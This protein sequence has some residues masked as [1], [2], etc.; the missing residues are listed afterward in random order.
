MTHLQRG[1]AAVV[2]LLL[3][4]AACSGDD[5]PDLSLPRDA[6]VPDASTTDE[7]TDPLLGETFHVAQATH[8]TLVV[9][10]SAQEGAD[11]LLTLVAAEQVSGKIVC[12]VV[13]QVGDWVE[14]RLPSGPT[15]RTGWV[16]RDDVAISRHHFRI[17][18]SRSEHTLTL[19]NGEIVALTTPVSLGPD[20][21]AA[22][23]RRFVTELVQPPD[24]SGPYDTYAY[25]L[26]GADNDLAAFTAGSGVVAIHGT[27]DAGALGDDAPSG[28]IGVGTDIVARMADTIGL[29]LGTPIDIVE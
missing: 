28:A 21:P 14:V 20:A 19:Y 5:T 25:G 24:R 2:S 7:T 15:D 11:E 10:S 16:A 13:Q 1:V 9:R 4:G 29:P 8:D 3:L 26:S 22:G 12:L 17:E 6:T 18:V 27:A 23:E